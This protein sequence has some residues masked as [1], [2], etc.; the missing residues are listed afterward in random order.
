MPRADQPTS[1]TDE[2]GGSGGMKDWVRNTVTLVALLGWAATLAGYLLQG[3]L[4]TPALLGVPGG[5]WLMMSPSLPNLP[6][7][8]TRSGSEQ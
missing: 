3:E 4:P 5:I 6:R 2:S 7:R 1:G 8:R